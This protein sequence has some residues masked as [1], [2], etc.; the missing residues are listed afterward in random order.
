MRPLGSEVT[1]FARMAS[2][3][4]IVGAVYWF[5]TYEVAGTVLLSTFG[6]A[7]AIAAIAVF[8]GSRRLRR[9]G[10]APHDEPAPRRPD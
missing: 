2:F 8:V 6:F 4:L 7:S 3:G 9:A 1:L 10:T 5:L